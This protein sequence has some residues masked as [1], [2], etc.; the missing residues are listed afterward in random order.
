MRARFTLASI[1][2]TCLLGAAAPAAAEEE[3]TPGAALSAA[4]CLALL[5]ARAEAV[6]AFRGT[7]ALKAYGAREGTFNLAF[8]YVPP[9]Q[10]RLELSTPLTG[11]VLVVTARGDEMLLY[12]PADNVAVVTA[13]GGPP[14]DPFGGGLYR[15][16]DWLAGRPE[17]YEVDVAAGAVTLAAEP[18]GEGRTAITWRRASD[19]ARLQQLTISAEPHHLLAARLYDGEEAI[20]DVTYGDWRA[21]GPAAMPYAVTFKAEDTVVEIVAR[22]IEVNVPM[23][24]AAFSTAPPEGAALREA[25]PPE[26]ERYEDD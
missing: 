4:E 11:T 16:V 20:F 15:L 13:A 2:I 12:Y 1:S 23:D 19:G 25:W 3:A 10:G 14:A 17:L 7:A 24:E 26:T 9:G 18:A 5:R 8:A 22:K 21:C 6:T